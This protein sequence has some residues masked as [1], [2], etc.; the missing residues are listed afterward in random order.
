MPLADTETAPTAY[1]LRVEESASMEDL[2][3]VQACVRLAELAETRTDELLAAKVQP[4]SAAHALDLASFPYNWTHAVTSAMWGSVDHLQTLASLLRS[5]DGVRPLAPYSLC[6]AAVENA[7]L[8]LWL[9]S[10]DDH[11][12]RLGRSLRLAAA[13]RRDQAAATRIT[14]AP[15]RPLKEFLAEID[16]LGVRGGLAQGS[17]LQRD[18][19]I[20][21]VSGADA[22]LDRPRRSGEFVWRLC[23]GFT[24]NRSWSRLA[25]LDRGATLDNGD[26]T[27][28]MSVTAGFTAIGLAVT[29][30]DSALRATWKRYDHDRKKW[31]VH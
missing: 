28:S 29:T 12:L 2:E 27:L 7:C 24:H 4:G 20:D 10:P 13:D 23:S 15:I 8:A 30:A 6:R 26:E 21:I 25:A 31:T 14:R 16:A 19:W 11:E 18:A 3:I 22:V 1:R 5:E 9:V 17:A